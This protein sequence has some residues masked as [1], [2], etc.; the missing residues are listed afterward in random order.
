MA[1]YPNSLFSSY[2]NN[3][4]KSRNK[5]RSMS[6]SSSPLSLKSPPLQ[7]ISCPDLPSDPKR[8]SSSHV[9]S[10][11]TYCLRIYPPTIVSELTRYVDDDITLTGRKFLRLKEEQLRKLNFDE[12]WVNLMMVGVKS[13][14][15][16][17]LKDKILLNG[18][19]ESSE[20]SGEERY[21]SSLTRNSLVRNS[22]SSTVSNTSS[23]SNN[24]LKDFLIPTSFSNLTSDDKIFISQE[25]NKLKEFLRSNI[26]QEDIITNFNELS[27]IIE[28]A[29]SNIEPKKEE[30]NNVCNNKIDEVEK[31]NSK[32]QNSLFWTKIENGFQGFMIGGI[33]VW[34][35]MRYSKW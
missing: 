8:W 14:R 30:N 23:Y 4:S 29:I 15:R 21:S 13:L 19:D 28:K 31:E 20:E 33:V 6:L 11:L 32:S 34:A 1:H 25:F 9:A 27:R 17:H 18:G 26:K 7:P 35:F 22:Y 5:H 3:S 12:T 2:S 16:D 10:Y 24:D